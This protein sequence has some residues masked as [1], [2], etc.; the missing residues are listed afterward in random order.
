MWFKKRTPEQFYDVAYQLADRPGARVRQRFPPISSIRSEHDAYADRHGRFRFAKWDAGTRIELIADT[1]N[2]RGRA[3]LDR[4]IIAPADPAT[5]ATQV[6]SGQADFM[7]SFPLDQVPKLDSSTVAR[8]V[9]MPQFGYAF[10]A[11]NPHARKSKT[12]AHPIFSRHR[13][14]RALSMAVDRAAMLQNVFGDTGRL[15][16]GRSR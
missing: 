11:M 14:R 2:Y 10:M 9:P 4:V 5:A 13:V 8:P 3:K 6:L 16:H 15:S 12:R 7:E 1:A